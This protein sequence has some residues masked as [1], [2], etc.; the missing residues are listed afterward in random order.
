MSQTLAERMT[1][2]QAVR[3]LGLRVAESDANFIWVHLPSDGGGSDEEAVVAGLRERRVLV[4]AGRSLGREGA[5]RV[6]VG[7]AAENESFAAALGELLA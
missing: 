3:G 2:E 5:L 4:R 7:T 6:T 1:L